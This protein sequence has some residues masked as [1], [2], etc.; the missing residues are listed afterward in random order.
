M[1]FPSFPSMSEMDDDDFR[2][3]AEKLDRMKLCLEDGRRLG[4]G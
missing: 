4:D 1:S 3:M 2:G